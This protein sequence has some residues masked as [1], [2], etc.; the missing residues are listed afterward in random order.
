[1]KDV[2]KEAK[3]FERSY[4]R[5][6]KEEQNASETILKTYQSQCADAQAACLSSKPTPHQ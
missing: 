6:S 5:M 3:D 4:S 1:M 2:C